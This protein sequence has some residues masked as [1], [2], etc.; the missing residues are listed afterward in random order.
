MPFNAKHETTEKNMT[1]KPAQASSPKSGR[2]APGTRVGLLIDW[3]GSSKSA[4][5]S[6]PY[7]RSLRDGK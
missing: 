6:D 3:R 2:K 7:G 1:V 5:L 4:I